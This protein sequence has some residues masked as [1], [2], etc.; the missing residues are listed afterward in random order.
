[1]RIKSIKL[2]F[3]LLISTLSLYSSEHREKHSHFYNKDL[4]YLN[5]SQEQTDAIKKIVKK[6]RQQMR[7][8]HKTKEVLEEK[9]RTVFVDENFNE[10]K[11]VMINNEL[12]KNKTQIEIEFFKEIH[13]I[14]NKSQREKFGNYLEEWEIE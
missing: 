12:E 7:Y 10:E 4:N 6:Y 8:F 9:K 3:I 5:L 11:L 1:M 2:L 14:L 13:P